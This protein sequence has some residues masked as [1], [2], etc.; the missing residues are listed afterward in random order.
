[1][2]VGLGLQRGWGCLVLRLLGTQKPLG[3]EGEKRG[4]LAGPEG[5]IFDLV[6][7]AAG[8]G[9]AW[10]WPWM[11][12]RRGLLQEIRQGLYRQRSSWQSSMNRGSPWF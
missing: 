12:T 2:K 4:A 9:L 8:L 6:V 3:V 11:G 5:S 7:G 1:V 10:C